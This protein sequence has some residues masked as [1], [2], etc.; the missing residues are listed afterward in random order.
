ML[1]ESFLFL[2][3]MKLIQKFEQIIVCHMISYAPGWLLISPQEIRSRDLFCR[4]IADSVYAKKVQ[5]SC[6]PYGSTYMVSK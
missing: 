5:A 6:F 4:D 2:S 1:K 3:V